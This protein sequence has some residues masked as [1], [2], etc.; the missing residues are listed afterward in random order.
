M[1]LHRIFLLILLFST[2]LFSQQ[3]PHGSLAEVGLDSVV[4]YHKID[5]IM[6]ASI[7]AEAFPGAQ[8]LVAKKG[9]I[10]FHKAYGT[11]TY[12]GSTAVGLTDIYDLASVTKITG[13]LPALMKLHSEG[14]FRFRCSFC[15]L[16]ACLAKEER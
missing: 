4:I 7:T 5:S 3:L 15:E 12:N 8:L 14:K 10:V 9:K 2:T 13:P 11:H 16:L 1:Q 6:K